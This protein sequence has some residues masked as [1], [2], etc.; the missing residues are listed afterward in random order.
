MQFDSLRAFPYPV[1]RPD[2]DDYVD[3]D[4]QVT[5]EF[6][7]SEDGQEVRAR[8]EFHLSVEEL[9][10]E[11]AAGRARY[12]IVFA[13]RDT[14][15]RHVELTNALEFEVTFP[16]G[17]LRGEVQIY[18][19]VSAAKQIKAYQAEW[20]NPEFGPGP[21]TY[22]VGAVLALDRPQVVYIDRDVFKPLSSIFVIRKD[23]NITGHE[24]QVRTTDDKVHILVSAE[25]KALIDNA[26]NNKSHRAVLMNSIYFAAVMHCLTQLKHGD[27]LDETRWGRVIAQ[28]CH[29]A[30]INLA[31]HEEYLVAERLM[32]SPFRL[33]DAYVFRGKRHENSNRSRCHC[34]KSARQHCSKPQPI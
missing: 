5:A 16:A 2:S 12:V 27:H 28:K 24:W 29:N 1:L 3:G 21:F 25:L 18:P 33:V 19:Y 14:Y 4:I 22:P 31:E 34:P 32:K 17:S 7:P 11:V 6:E 20:I 15:F 10:A 23:E 8:V 26:R 9:K 13:C 30:G